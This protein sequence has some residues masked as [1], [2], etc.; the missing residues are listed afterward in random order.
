MSILLILFSFLL[1]SNAF[2]GEQQP[3]S[4]PAI[5]RSFEKEND[6]KLFRFM[7]GVPVG[8]HKPDASLPPVGFIDSGVRSDH[9]QLLGLIVTEKDFTGEGVYDLSGHGTTVA[10]VYVKSLFD[11]KPDFESITGQELKLTGIA[12][13]K[14]IGTKPVSMQQIADRIIKAIRWLA[15]LGVQ[16]VNISMALPEGTADYAVLCAE[17]ES[18]KN[19]LFVIA[20]G[21]LG[22]GSVVFPSACSASNKIVTGAVT[23][24]GDVHDYSGPADIVAPLPPAMI[25]ESEFYRKEADQFAQSG[26]LNEA[27]IYYKKAAE[28]STTSKDTA[29]IEYG[30]GYIA[31]KQQRKDEALSHFRASVKA[32]P[33]YPEPYISI[34]FILT[35]RQ[36]FDRAHQLLA[37]GLENGAD[38]TRLRDR[39]ARVLLDLGQAEEALEQIE[40]LERL[41]SSFKGLGELRLAVQNRLNILNFIKKGTDPGTLLD[42]LI[43][44]GDD[45]NLVKFMILRTSLDVNTIPEGAKITP[46]ASAAFY[47]RRLITRVLIDNSASVDLHDPKYKLT[48]LMMAA[49]VGEVRIVDMLIKEGASLDKQDYFG[50][51]ALMFAAEQGH[52]RCA[53]ALLQ[54][55]ANIEHI[56]QKGKSAL[57][58][59]KDHGHDSI[60]QEIQRVKQNKGFP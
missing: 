22:P 55:G 44:A 48:A 41:D 39:Y 16:I 29:L 24:T 17:I 45:A 21:N 49:N 35:S 15:G 2:A 11:S 4:L 31:Y 12:S 53:E 7:P 6:Q 37:R 57:D 52:L 32:W 59:A 50:F 26:K 27:K 3:P 1:E 36:E 34:S 47:K 19:I 20:A 25:S 60:V 58:Y 18:Q 54:A 38:S 51:T 5:E 14:V 9:P 30:L 43:R 8:P 13:A 23:P 42:A 56:S 40:S 10:L 46:L 33:S 28:T